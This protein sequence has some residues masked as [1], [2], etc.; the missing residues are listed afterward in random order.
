[1]PVVIRPAVPADAAALADIYNQGIEDRVATFET[2]ARTA[3]DIDVWLS[4]PFPVIVAEVDGAVSAFARLLPYRD[5]QCYAAIRE[6]SVYVARSARGNGLA[7]GVMQ[8]LIKHARAAHITKVI[9]RIF[10]ENTASL[11]LCDKLGFRRVGVYERHGQLDG[12]WRDCAIVELL[13]NDD[14]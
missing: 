14:A 3:R 2:T 4:G 11:A 6:F 13:L 7:T 8:R 9:A 12:R 5:R 10:I 1:M